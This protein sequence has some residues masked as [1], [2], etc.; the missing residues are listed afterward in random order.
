MLSTRT[1]RHLPAPPYSRQ[2]PLIAWPLQ[3]QRAQTSG[4]YGPNKGL[5]SLDRRRV[6]SFKVFSSHC[7]KTLKFCIL[8]ISVDF[9]LDFPVFGQIRHE[10]SSSELLSLP[11]GEAL[12]EPFGIPLLSQGKLRPSSDNFGYL[13]QNQ[14]PQQSS[15]LHNVDG[16]NID[17]SPKRYIV[18]LFILDQ[19]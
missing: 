8:T 18:L 16:C 4:C 2:V 5:P 15:S 12:G 6:Q 1:A 11:E 3:V 10:H 14:E 7:D 19:F 17:P 9:D 13:T